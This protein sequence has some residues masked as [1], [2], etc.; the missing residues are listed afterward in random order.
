MPSADAWRMC[1]ED[2][3]KLGKEYI[4]ALTCKYYTFYKQNLEAFD[5]LHNTHLFPIKY[6]KVI[7]SQK[8]SGF[9]AHP[10]CLTLFTYLSY[11]S[12]ASELK[13]D[14]FSQTALVSFAINCKF[15]TLWLLTQ[16]NMLIINSCSHNK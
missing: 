6:H 15:N 4:I 5:I 13:V 14:V 11:D 2:L 9:L 7:D 16:N 8:K 10:V 3:C 1:S 12:K